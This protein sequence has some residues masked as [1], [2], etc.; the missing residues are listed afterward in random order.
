MKKIIDNK[1]PAVI[2]AC[3]TPAGFGLVRSLHP[4]GIPIIGLDCYR[5][6]AG[7]SRKFKFE[8]CPDPAR[9]PDRFIEHLVGIGKRLGKAALFS[10][11]DLSYFLYCFH[12]ERLEP[13]FYFPYTDKNVLEAVLDKWKMYE[14]ART[15]GIPSPDTYCPKNRGEVERRMFK[16]PVVIKPVTC[17]FHIGKN[18]P[19]KVNDFLEAYFYKKVLRAEN[20][21]QLL[22]YSEKLF[23]KGFP[24]IVQEEIPGLYDELYDVKFYTDQQGNT[25]DWFVGKKI[26]QFPADFGIGCLGE[27]APADLLK[28]YSKRF[29]DTVGYKGIGDIEYKYDYRDKTYKFIEINPRSTQQ[30]LKSTFVGINIPLQQYEDMTGIRFDH[31]PSRHKHVNWL[32]LETDLSY[33][34]KHWLDKKS[35]Y[36]VTARQWIGSIFKKPLVEAYLSWDDPVL[37]LV[38]L[39][40]CTVLFAMK[41]TKNV[42]LALTG[43]NVN[44]R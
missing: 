2:F 33:F 10:S 34:A 18:G 43:I 9:E 29:A 22:A 38:Y 14:A 40:R 11:G 31:L 26:R 37:S 3:N 41:L 13:Y 39:S 21:D 12:R 8:L 7:L 44:K 30:S 16:Y 36:R 15:A 23:E 1:I 25:R 5:H 28:D 27:D 19:E 35:P 24:F 17:Q 6:F 20:Q 42:I 32:M 4:Y